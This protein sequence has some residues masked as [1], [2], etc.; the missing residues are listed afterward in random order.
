MATYREVIYCKDCKYR[1]SF[2]HGEH[3]NYGMFSYSCSRL[4]L[5][6]PKPFDFCSR[7]EYKE[8]KNV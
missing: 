6:D 4:E 8:K 7:A 2:Y 1:E 3:S 5:R